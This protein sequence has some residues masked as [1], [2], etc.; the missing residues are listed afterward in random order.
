M[1]AIKIFILIV[2]IVILTILT[3]VTLNM[4]TTGEKGRDLALKIWMLQVLATVLQLY[5]IL[6]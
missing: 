1:I 2:L 5:T 6:N 4:Y 3:S